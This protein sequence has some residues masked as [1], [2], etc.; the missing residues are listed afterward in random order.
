MD[1]RSSASETP[2]R[3][4][5]FANLANR[6]RLADLMRKVG[7]FYTW[8]GELA[9]FPRAHVLIQEIVD[10]HRDESDRDAPISAV[11]KIVELRTKDQQRVDEEWLR[12]RTKE[13]VGLPSLELELAKEGIKRIANPG[14]PPMMLT[15]AMDRYAPFNRLLR[16]RL[17][18]TIEQ[19]CF[20]ES[21]ITLRGAEAIHPFVTGDSPPKRRMFGPERYPRLL[22]T[23]PSAFVDAYMESGRYSPTR[24]KQARMPLFT[25]RVIGFLT[26]TPQGFGS[27]KKSFSRWAFVDLGDGECGVV[28]TQMLADTL[29][30]AV[31]IGLIEKL[32]ERERG[33]Y[34][35][36]VGRHYE[37]LIAGLFRE[38]YREAKIRSRVK[39]T[40]EAGDA[41]VLVETSPTFRVLVMCKGK[42]LQPAARWGAQPLFLDNLARNVLEGVNQ[43]KKVVKALSNT[44]PIASTFVVLDAYFPSM[45]LLAYV[46]STLGD[47]TEG[48]P[49]PVVTTHYDLA[50]LLTKIR[51]DELPAY[52]RWRDL[53]LKPRRLRVVDEFDLVRAYINTASN[54]LFDWTKPGPVVSFLG[55][56]RE[57]DAILQERLG[58]RLQ[59]WARDL[60]QSTQGEVNQDR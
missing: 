30:S 28:V 60:A 10:V 59:D 27:T 48:L 58:T 51:P 45:A 33:V 56:D 40:P 4:P 13:P 57:Y 35:R 46:E 44:E 22:L 19:A 49:F 41:D 8:N 9:G 6:F 36:E 21:I 18:F 5:E 43:A 42:L 16:E 14:P 1:S 37:D 24:I 29:V 31:Q 12:N 11:R 50:Y 32:D 2:S 26:S 7:A 52:L 54:P 25:E 47:F 17:G 20:S 55:A 39:V 38:N 53:A 15:Y 23:P 3:D 34:G